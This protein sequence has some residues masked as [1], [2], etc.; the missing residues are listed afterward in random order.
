MNSLWH[1]AMESPMPYLANQ[2]RCTDPY[3]LDA[4][5]VE[6]LPIVPHTCQNMTAVVSRAS[7]PGASVTQVICVVK[8]RVDALM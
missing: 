1:I 4:V 2:S 5:C 7:R 3:L 8:P 6:L